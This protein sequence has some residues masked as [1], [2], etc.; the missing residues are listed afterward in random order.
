MARRVGGFP[1]TAFFNAAHA[2][3]RVESRIGKGELPSSITNGI[4][5]QPST[6]ASQRSSVLNRAMRSMIRAVDSRFEIDHRPIH[7]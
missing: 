6:T 5:V 2:S 7:P 4:S 1:A 3:N